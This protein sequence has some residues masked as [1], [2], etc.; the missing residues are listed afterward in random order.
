MNE[1]TPEP[2]P[3]PA[4][5]PAPVQDA[6]AEVASEP[7]TEASPADEAAPAAEAGP[8]VA[9]QL[10]ALF[11]A[12]FTGGHKPLKLR[13]QADIQERAPGQFTKAQLSAF[14]RR[15]TGNTGYLIALTKSKTRFDLDGNEAG[16][17]SEEHLAAA[18]EELTRRRNLKNERVAA[19]REQ[20]NLLVQQRRNRAGLLWDFERTTLTLKNFCTL[21]GVS[22]EELPGLLDI[23]R[24]ERSEMPPREERP[25]RQGQRPDQ[26]PDQRREGGQRRDGGQRP[27]RGEQQQRREGR[28]TSAPKEG[29]RNASR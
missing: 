11:P 5:A 9:A 29:R 17:L 26:R 20:E 6:A 14:F 16:E 27:P 24:K 23:A 19:E 3:T 15:Y 7:I 1:T 25:Q 4:E 28:P 22:E 12:L 21:K 8:D 10:K 18:K 2:I 13:I